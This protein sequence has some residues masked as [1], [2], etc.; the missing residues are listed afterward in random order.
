[1]L[2]GSLAERRDAHQHGAACTRHPDTIV[3]DRRVEIPAATMLLEEGVEV[4][5]Q[6]SVSLISRT[7]RRY[8]RS[9]CVNV[10][11]CG[12]YLPFGPRG[13]KVSGRQAY[14]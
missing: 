7:R 13:S 2:P 1:M 4:G 14:V 3:L 12:H 10:S 5:E 6:V 8:G 9:H 11:D